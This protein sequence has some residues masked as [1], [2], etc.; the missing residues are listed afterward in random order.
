MESMNRE[1]LRTPKFRARE[2]NWNK[3]RALKRGSLVSDIR[4]YDVWE[5]KKVFQEGGMC[6]IPLRIQEL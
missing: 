5:V 3:Q 2:K 1:G 6:Q 4:K